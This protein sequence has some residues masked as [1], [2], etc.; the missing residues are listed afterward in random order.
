[1]QELINALNE[2][3]FHDFHS[4]V[5]LLYRIDINE[6]KLKQALQ[7]NTNTN[8]G[9][10]IAEMILQRLAEKEKTKQQFKQNEPIDD[11]ERW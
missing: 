7:E 1:K 3:I 5:R 10:M 8:A 11:D 6:K 9:E 2:L 4:L